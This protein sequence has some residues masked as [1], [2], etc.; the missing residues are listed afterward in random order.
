[1]VHLTVDALV[2]GVVRLSI[3]NNL[4]PY[5][6]LEATLGLG[7]QKTFYCKHSDFI[8]T[9]IGYGIHLQFYFALIKSCAKKG[10]KDTQGA[11][12]WTPPTV[13]KHTYTSYSPIK[14]N[15]GPKGCNGLSFIIVRSLLY[16]VG[17]AFGTRGGLLHPAT[18]AHISPFPWHYSDHGDHWMRDVLGISW[19]EKMV[20]WGAVRLVG[21]WGWLD[22]QHFVVHPFFPLGADHRQQS[23]AIQLSDPNIV[24]SPLLSSS[25]QNDSFYPFSTS[26]VF[27]SSNS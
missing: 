19:A 27:L 14:W 21:N 7:H 12:T 26:P 9:N 5:H 20:A 25:S 16:R 23:F 22:G 13:W 3:N 11:I 10:I 8:I 4:S 2:N 6:P 17:S 18:C 15:Q 24:Y 1:M